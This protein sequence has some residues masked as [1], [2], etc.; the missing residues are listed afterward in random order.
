METDGPTRLC[1]GQRHWSA[2]CPDGKVMCCI[3][4]GRFSLDE[5]D[6]ADRLE[7]GTDGGRTDVCRQCGEEQREAME[8]IGKG[9]C[10]CPPYRRNGMCRHVVPFLPK[11]DIEAKQEYL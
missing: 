10:V 3:C 5:L 8:R 9:I 7:D 6:E 11:E 2:A 1:C 4:F